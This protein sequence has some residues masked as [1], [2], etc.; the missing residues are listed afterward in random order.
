M[1]AR[2]TGWGATGDSGA[3]GGWRK[4][5]GSSAGFS[6]R[7]LRWAIGGTT[8]AEG[9]TSARGRSVVSGLRGF[10]SL[11]GAAVPRLTGSTGGLPTTC[12]SGGSVPTCST[13]SAGLRRMS[14]CSVVPAAGAAGTTTTGGVASPDVAVDSGSSVLLAFASAWLVVA[15]GGCGSLAG[16]AGCRKIS[17]ANAGVAGGFGSGER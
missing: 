12:S 17:S 13:G 7:G 10:G 8:G 9:S 14:G 6:G 15:A 11:S 5:S 16:S 4:T 3:G 1:V 2:W